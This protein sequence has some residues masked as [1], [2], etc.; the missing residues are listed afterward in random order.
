MGITK[1]GRE[2]LDWATE[3]MLQEHRMDKINQA[4]EM[5]RR[6]QKAQEGV[7]EIM[8]DANRN[9][10]FMRIE[11]A[12]VELTFLDAKRSKILREIAD[13]SSK[14]GLTE[15]ERRNWL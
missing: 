8:A 10:K 13:L 6:G 14:L 12:R 9:E 4:A 2:K 15:S 3:R 7:D 1:A 5:V 11:N